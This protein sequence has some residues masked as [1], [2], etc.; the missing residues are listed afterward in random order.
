MSKGKNL[1]DDESF[2]IVY[3]R[4]KS[5]YGP[6]TT[7]DTE[8]DTKLADVLQRHGRKVPK[9]F[10]DLQRIVEPELVKNEDSAPNKT[11]FNLSSLLSRIVGNRKS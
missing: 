4:V 1:L 11:S 3:N 8:F 6:K 5:M 2:K 10:L 9:S 7:R